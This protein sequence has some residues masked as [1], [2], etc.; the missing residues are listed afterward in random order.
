LHVR[1]QLDGGSEEKIGSLSR[2]ER[3][4][5]MRYWKSTVQYNRRW[6][7]EIVISAIKRMFGENLRAIK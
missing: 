1:R 5:N 7:V 3:R 4:E 2:D 6:L